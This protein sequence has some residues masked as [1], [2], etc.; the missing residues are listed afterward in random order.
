MIATPTITPAMANH[1]ERTTRSR[2]TIQ[3]R[4]AANTG[5][6]LYRKSALATVECMTAQ[7]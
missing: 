2:S 5:A 6:G 3:P 7:T 4:S 1:I